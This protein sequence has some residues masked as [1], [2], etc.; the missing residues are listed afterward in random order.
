MV[1]G[2]K[3]RRDRIIETVVVSFMETGE[4]V[5]SAHVSATCG[6]GLKPA[7]IRA[8]MREL[9]E[10]GFLVQPHTSAGRV[11]TVKCYRYYVRHLMP[12]IALPDT[13]TSAIKKAIEEGIR[14]LDADMFMHHMACVLSEL[15]DLIGVAMLPDFDQGIFERMDIV[16]LGGSTYLLVLSLKNGLI[17][18]IRITVDDV[19]PRSR[20]AE[21]SRRLTERLQ[22][23]TIKEIKDEIGSRLKDVP[24]GDR[25]LVE[26]VVKKRERI[27]S[28]S[29]ERNIHLAGLSRVLSHPDFLPHDN[30]LKLIDMFEHK[31]E[32]IDALKMHVSGTG[33]VSI[34]IGGRGPWG[35]RPPLALV[36]AMYTVGRGSGVVGVIGPARVHYPKLTALVKYAAAYTTH[37]FSS[38]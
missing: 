11:P 17:N 5:S 28:F 37:F 36:S 4:P 29:D 12:R 23:L 31:N 33:D 9:E 25:R 1:A 6:L 16:G 35:S 20:V 10:D 26:I 15:T 22:G 34:S 3:E 18:T 7:S 24:G 32:I 8:L 2:W 27:F 13:E 21:T 38:C 30:S 14:E 19:I